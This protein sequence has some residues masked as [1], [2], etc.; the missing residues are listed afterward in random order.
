MKLN[1]KTRVENRFDM[2]RE[3]FA[4]W[5]QKYGRPLLSATK[6]TEC[7][8]IE[9]A[10]TQDHWKRATVIATSRTVRGQ[11]KNSLQIKLRG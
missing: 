5:W 6:V 10:L 4:D 7:A 11:R 9:K 1:L 3:Q 2:S 8:V